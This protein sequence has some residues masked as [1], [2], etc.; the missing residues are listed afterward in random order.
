MDI[1]TGEV[2]KC[3]INTL[4]YDFISTFKSS[5]CRYNHTES[6]VMVKNRR[7]RSDNILTTLKCSPSI[8]MWSSIMGYSSSLTVKRVSKYGVPIQFTPRTKYQ[9]KSFHIYK[10]MTKEL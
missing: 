7:K 4:T 5:K 6:L 2:L 9:N 8:K 10:R 1:I 3:G